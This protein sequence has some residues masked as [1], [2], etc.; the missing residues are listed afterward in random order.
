MDARVSSRLSKLQEESF[1]K[2]QGEIKRQSLFMIG[3][4]R[5]SRKQSFII[6]ETIS[7]LKK[8]SLE[9]GHHPSRHNHE[10]IKGDAF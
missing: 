9:E 10:S 1:Q 3:D 8:S 7:Y 6:A 4:D 5:V 2:F